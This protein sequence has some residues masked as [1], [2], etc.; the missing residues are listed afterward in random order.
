M[1]EVISEFLLVETIRQIPTNGVETPS[2][3]SN[4]N[5]CART[6][7]PCVNCTGIISPDIHYPLH[8]QKVCLL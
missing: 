3:D 5:P 1:W 8:R 2:V 4:V 7:Y 6:F